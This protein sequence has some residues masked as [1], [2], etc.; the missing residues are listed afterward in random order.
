M[1]KL[2]QNEEVLKIFLQ[3]LI[4]GGG[5]VGIRMSWVENFEKLISGVTSIRDQRVAS[6]MQKKNGK[7]YKERIAK[8]GT[9]LSIDMVSMQYSAVLSRNEI[10][11]CNLI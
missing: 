9:G 8:L 3:N 11:I 5:G 10:I 7:H 6:N 4:S 2:R 1:E